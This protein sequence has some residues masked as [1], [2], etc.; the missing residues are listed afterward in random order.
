M[1]ELVFG[2]QVLEK[3]FYYAVDDTNW[4]RISP[5]VRR[6]DG[7][8]KIV[9]VLTVWYEHDYEASPIINMPADMTLTPDNIEYQESFLAS[10]FDIA[11]DVLTAYDDNKAVRVRCNYPIMGM[12]KV[13]CNNCNATGK[14][15]DP[16]SKEHV[17]CSNCDGGYLKAPSP[18]QVLRAAEDGLLGQG[19]G[20]KLIEF[21]SP[22]VGVLQHSFDVPRELRTEMRKILGLD[23]LEGAGANSSDLALE[24]RE[25]Y[26]NDLYSKISNAVFDV[27]D[28]IL[29]QVS[30]L[31][32]LSEHKQPKVLRP[33]DFNIKSISSLKKQAKEA[34]GEDRIAKRIKLYES[35]Y[36]NE[37][38]ELKIKKAIIL[39]FP[40]TVLEQQELNS[41]FS[42]QAVTAEDCKKADYAYTVLWLIA[43][44]MGPRFEELELM[45]LKELMD[46]KFLEMG[47]IVPIEEEQAIEGDGG[48]GGEILNLPQGGES[49]AQ[50][51][52]PQDRNTQID[53]VIALFL[54]GEIDAETTENQLLALTDLD[55]NQ[56]RQILEN[57]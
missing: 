21:Y 51:Q 33:I 37:P 18:D 43:D 49:Q 50:T 16:K 36:K 2:G 10:F 7:F 57:A 27:L 31:L 48:Q 32:V 44:E 47:I 9:Y 46:E 56:I 38:V 20:G 54:S 30:N 13:K 17:A 42:K 34:L 53:G 52:E 25:R 55:R 35:E 8:E 24:R 5:Q 15:Y 22:D 29:D 12:A 28:L 40:F 45:E 1:D 6:E 19:E 39:L 11:R 14:I 26:V 3:E 23:L 41:R 4:Y